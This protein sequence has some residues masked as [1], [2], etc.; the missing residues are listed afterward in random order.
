MTRRLG[1]AALGA[2]LAIGCDSSGVDG[3]DLRGVFDRPTASAPTTSATATASKSAAPKASTSA[4][5]EAPRIPAR[6]RPRVKGRCVADAGEPAALGPR[7]AKRPACRGARV[8]ERR[9]EGRVPRYGCVYEPSTLDSTKPLPLVIFLHAEHADPGVIPKVTHLR[10]DNH[11]VDMTGDPRHLGFVVL[12]PQA[13]RLERG[14][15]WDTDYTAA[16]NDDLETIDAFVDDL[17]REGVVDPRQIYAIGHGS[18][19]AMAALYA[20]GRPDRVAAFGV[21]GAAPRLS[22]RCDADPTPAAVLYRACDTVTPCGDV[23]QWLAVRER[24]RAPTFSLRLGLDRATEPSCALSKRAC[25][26]KKGRAN[27]ARWPRSREAD[28]LE[29]LS[30]FSLAPSP[31]GAGAPGE[32]P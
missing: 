3:G 23:E 28:L 19:G 4:A 16:D 25:G 15:R 7:V 31:A 10:R 2:L 20:Y 9:D 12:A 14:V 1:S 11:K 8:I 18:G 22:W 29:Y 27:H 6:V 26:D 30:R 24:E 13:R 5:A 32:A 21:F 17:E